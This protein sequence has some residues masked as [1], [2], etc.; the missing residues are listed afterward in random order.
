MFLFTTEML[1]RRMRKDERKTLKKRFDV[2]D[3]DDNNGMVGDYC[4]LPPTN[5]AQVV[6]ELKGIHCMYM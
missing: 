3:D 6:Y 5:R 4:K 2:D 1:I